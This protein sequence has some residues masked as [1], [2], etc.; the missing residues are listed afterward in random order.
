MKQQIEWDMPRIQHTEYTAITSLLYGGLVFLCVFACAGAFNDTFSLGISMPLL[1]AWILGLSLFL[2]FGYRSKAGKNISGLVFLGVFV[3]LVLGNRAAVNSGYNAILNDMMT[4]LSDKL[5]MQ[6][7]QTYQESYTPREEAKTLFYFAVSGFL[8]L[9]I[10][11]HIH[12][13]SSIGQVFFPTFLL[14]QMGIFLGMAPSGPYLALLGLYYLG[15]WV[16]HRGGHQALSLKRGAI[17]KHWFFKKGRPVYTYTSNGWLALQGA[18]WFLG[19]CLLLG[20][21]LYPFRTALALPVS[22]M[23][24]VS[25]ERARDFAAVLAEQGITGLLADRQGIGGVNGG[26]LGEI[27]RVYPDFQTDILVKTAPTSTDSLNIIQNVYDTYEDN[28]WS[29]SQKMEETV[30]TYEGAVL[31]ENLLENDTA[32]VSKNLVMLQYVDNAVYPASQEL[33]YT[34]ASNG[35]GRNW[36]SWIVQPLSLLWTDD[37]QTTIPPEGEETLQVPGDLLGELK[38]LGE[39]IG[40]SGSLSRQVETLLDYFSANL[41]YTLA[42]GKTP[43]GEDFVLYFLEEQQKGYCTYFA[44]AAALLLRAEG[45]PTRYVEGY[46]IDYADMLNGTLQAEETFGDWV[47]GS[48]SL[49]ETAVVETAVTDV[50]AHAWIEVYSQELGWYPV[51]VTVGANLDEQTDDTMDFWTYFGNQISEMANTGDVSSLLPALG[52][53]AKSVGSILTAAMPLLVAVGGLCA[54]LLW[55]FGKGRSVLWNG[56][57]L[58]FGSPAGKGALLCAH[59]MRKVAGEREDGPI[60]PAL[61][62]RRLEAHFGLPE[63]EA[64]AMAEEMEGMLFAPGKVSINQLRTL[65][66]NMKNVKKYMGKKTQN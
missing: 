52:K 50:M 23:W 8:V 57:I 48:S 58:C 33:Y 60:T 28:Q 66:K 20:M 42:P 30:T 59:F 3:V 10:N 35:G 44:S 40:L 14:A 53:T 21:L 15:L 55:G 51:E 36:S 31:M 65:K 1:A 63:K 38:T 39:T 22:S 43:S 13:G 41:S 29:K 11:S 24:Q 37:L 19:G 64:K 9:L 27:S 47:T 2:S 32:G 7:V 5:D 54:L 12:G 26:K 46:R 61:T 45:I 34:L 56:W 49:G 17:R 18:G 62:A 4:V 16:L 25:L 6:A